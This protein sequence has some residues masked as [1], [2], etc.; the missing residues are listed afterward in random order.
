MPSPTAAQRVPRLSPPGHR[1]SGPRGNRS[2]GSGRIRA[3][4]VGTISSAGLFGFVERLKL[5]DRLAHVNVKVA[6]H[7]VEDLDDQRMA[8]G[9]EHLIPG[10]GAGRWPGNTRPSDEGHFA[11]T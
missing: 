1:R 2:A 5:R 9:V 10:F 4:I 11:Y 8:Q 7:D 3:T 6:A